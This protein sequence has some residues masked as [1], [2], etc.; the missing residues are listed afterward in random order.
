M[1]VDKYK[2]VIEIISSNVKNSIIKEALLKEGFSAEQSLNLI[3][4]YKSWNK[5]RF[6]VF[7]KD[8]I[9]DGLNSINKSIEPTYGYS[10]KIA[11]WS[12]GNL[13]ME[14]G[15]GQLN[16]VFSWKTLINTQIITGESTVFVK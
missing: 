14:G 16:T 15:A 7:G 12:I 9:V 10:G 6:E 1:D 11:S 5:N 4:E 3:N 8:G 2:K 13:K